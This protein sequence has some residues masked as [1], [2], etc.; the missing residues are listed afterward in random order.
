MLR[1][2]QLRAI[3]PA[4]LFYYHYPSKDIFY[5]QGFFPVCLSLEVQGVGILSSMA[6][7]PHRQ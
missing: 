5:S 4:R 3:Y 7:F 2:F 6:G 1:W